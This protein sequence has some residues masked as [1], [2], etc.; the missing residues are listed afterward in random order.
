MNEQHIE[1]IVTSLY[2]LVQDARAMPLSPDKCI[3]ERDKILDMLDELIAQ[4]PAE[5]QQA[6]AFDPAQYV[7]REEFEAL[8]EK[9]DAL[10]ANRMP[11]KAVKAKEDK[12]DE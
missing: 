4:M 11:V 7:T 12:T 2:D 3:V 8:S 9:L 10:Q 1:D 6:A 5:L